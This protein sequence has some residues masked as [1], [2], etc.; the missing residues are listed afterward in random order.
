[1]ISNLTGG[2]ETFPLSFWDKGDLFFGGGERYPL[3]EIER[4]LK[5]RGDT[6]VFF[7]KKAEKA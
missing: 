1:M 2:A 6:P 3:S 4:F 7:L 5:V